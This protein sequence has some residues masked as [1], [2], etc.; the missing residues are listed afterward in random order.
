MRKIAITGAKGLIGWHARAWL[1]VQPETQVVRVPKAAWTDAESLAGLLE[2]CDAV[3][4]LAAMNRGADAE[5]RE[6]NV[7]L[8]RTLVDALDRLGGTPHVLHSSSTLAERDT[9]THGTYGR[10]KR[11]ASEILS[12][13]AATSGGAFTDMILPNVFGEG[14]RAFHNSVVSTFCHLLATGGEPKVDVDNEI[15]FLHAHQV[16]CG[17]G[18]LIA[19]GATEEW[20]PSG[21]RITVSALLDT[22]KD[23]DSGYRAHF[24]PDLRDPFARDLFNTY[25]S[26]LYPDHYPVAFERH[27]DQR[28]TL[29]EAIREGNG[30]QVHYSNTHPGFT[31]GEHFH[32]R[33][34]ERFVVISG[35]AEIAIRRICGA[36]I[37]RFRVS[38]EK[39][40]YVDMPTLH[41]HN[42]TNT[43]SG[44]MIAMFWSN[45]LYD[46]AAPD[47]YR[48]PVEL[49][50]AAGAETTGGAGNETPGKV[51]AR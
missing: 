41:T 25:R 33:K 38:G 35:E 51:I 26:Y 48:V 4:H 42:L 16:A 11:E 5:I 22:L 7:R 12:G 32:F 49:E 9:G 29:V 50:A 30:G 31:R 19:Q 36:E 40:V 20:R 15:A 17:I 3:V 18:D 44:D 24:I 21:T 47:T 43:G 37:M 14:G 27:T 39:P 10:S 1:S 45:E 8:A 23:M 2:G 28:G 34:V 13:W 46:P 6:T